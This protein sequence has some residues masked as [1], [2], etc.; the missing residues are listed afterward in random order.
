[1]LLTV[2]GVTKSPDWV[3]KK[4]RGVGF[5]GDMRLGTRSNALWVSTKS[6]KRR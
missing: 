1:M 6:G 2:A 5:V 3:S 4:R